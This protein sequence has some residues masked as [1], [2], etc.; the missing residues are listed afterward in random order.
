LIGTTKRPDGTSQVTY[1]GHPVYHFQGDH[2]PGETNGEGITAFGAS[3]FALSPSGSAV[4]SPSS[5]TGSG[6]GLGY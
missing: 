6:S 3:W 2:N 1:N 5:N 4:T